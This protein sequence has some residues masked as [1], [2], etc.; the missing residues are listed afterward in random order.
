MRSGLLNKSLDTV[1]FQLQ[2]LVAWVSVAYSLCISI[3]TN[4]GKV[5]IFRWNS[6]VER[7]RIFICN[8][9]LKAKSHWW[10]K[11]WFLCKMLFSFYFFEPGSLSLLLTMYSSVTLNFWPSCFY[12]LN[13][14]I[15]HM[16]HHSQHARQFLKS[17]LPYT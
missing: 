7:K 2:N 11:K 10:I 8:F 1:L 12:L 3:A 17:L 5:T 6:L 14:R 9:C 16:S 4:S 13:T 15:T